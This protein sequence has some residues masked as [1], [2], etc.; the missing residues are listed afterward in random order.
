ML[1]LL[2]SFVVAMLSFAML[3]SCL[4]TRATLAGPAASVIYFLTYLAYQLVQATN[5]SEPTF[6]AVLS[7]VSGTANIRTSKDNFTVI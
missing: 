1:L 4:F 3:V 2:V 7:A 6:A 5:D